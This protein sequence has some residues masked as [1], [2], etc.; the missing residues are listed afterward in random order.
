M[1]VQIVDVP[2]RRVAAS[3]HS[4]AYPRISEAFERLGALLGGASE[5]SGVEAKRFDRAS[6]MTMLASYLDDPNLVPEAELRSYAA[7]VLAAGERAPEGLVELAVGGGLYAKT[8][9][10]GPYSGLA[11]AWR[12]LMVEWQRSAGARIDAR[13]WFEIYRNTPGQVPLDELETELYLPLA[14]LPSDAPRP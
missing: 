12:W 10:R 6:P 9:H 7:I 13:P 14:S 8:T 2:E 11:E 1:D 3:L 4:G 5:A